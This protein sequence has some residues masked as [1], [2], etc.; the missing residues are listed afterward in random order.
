MKHFFAAAYHTDMSLI[1][2]DYVLQRG[3]GLEKTQT[4]QKSASAYSYEDLVSNLIGVYFEEYLED[5]KVNPEDKEAMEA[6]RLKG[7]VYVL[8]QFLKE[9]GVVDD[10]TKAP[11]YNG[12]PINY[13][14][15]TVGN[16]PKNKTYTPKNTT[17]KRDKKIDAPSLFSL[18]WKVPLSFIGDPLFF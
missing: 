4:K 10:E 8:E 6:Y 18:L 3:E 1:S 9:I 5:F 15:Q 11:N 13:E 7:Q 2:G 17:E 14:T 12:L 16:V